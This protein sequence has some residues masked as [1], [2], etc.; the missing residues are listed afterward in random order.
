MGRFGIQ[1]LLE[2][3]TWSTKFHKAKN[4]NYGNSSRE[5]SLLNL[6]FTEPNYGIR[7]FYDK[8]D[9]THADKCFSNIT[10]IH[11]VY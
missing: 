6:D 9:T 8:I 7:L 1:I 3:N 2:D 5:W 10:I 11:S 4:S